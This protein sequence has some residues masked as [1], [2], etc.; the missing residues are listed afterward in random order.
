MDEKYRKKLE[1]LIN[2]YQGELPEFINEIEALWIKSKAEPNVLQDFLV[3]VHNM[4][5]T[6]GMLGFTDISQIAANIQMIAKQKNANLSENNVTEI[7]ELVAR[8]KSKIP[9]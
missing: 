1:P 4:K 3:K 5:G 2:K 6:S 7:N 9:Q 8:L